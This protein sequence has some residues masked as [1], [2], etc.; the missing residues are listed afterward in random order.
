MNSHSKTTTW[1]KVHLFF[2][3]VKLVKS[4]ALSAPRVLWNSKLS[5]GC[6]FQNLRRWTVVIIHLLFHTFSD[7]LLIW[8]TAS[9]RLRIG[10]LHFHSGKHLIGQ[11]SVWCSEFVTIY[12]TLYDLKPNSHRL[13]LS[14]WFLWYRNYFVR[15][16][17][18]CP[19]MHRM[20]S[21][22]LNTLAIPMLCFFTPTVSF[23]S[24]PLFPLWI[25]ASNRK[26]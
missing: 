25:I 17:R 21:T 9:C 19:W 7:M 22:I 10:W 23:P 20:S 18:I 16:A 4:Y 12:P 8:C 5:T 1:L 6:S 24:P 13:K 14:F 3:L 15:I 2:F 11:K 26:R